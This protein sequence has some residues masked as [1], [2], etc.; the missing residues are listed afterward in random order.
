MSWITGIHKSL[1]PKILVDNQVH[2]EGFIPCAMPVSDMDESESKDEA[3]S[4][5][6]SLNM[7]VS[8]L[9]EQTVIVT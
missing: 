2:F 9:P 4:T 3:P 6:N 5:E 7:D 8:T 1:R